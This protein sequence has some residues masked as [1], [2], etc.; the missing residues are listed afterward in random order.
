MAAPSTGMTGL[1]TSW[2][3]TANTALLAACDEP[4]FTLNI[5]G[6]VQ[7]RTAFAAGLTTTRAGATI[8]GWSGTI[9]G[10]ARLGTSPPSGYLGLVTFAGGYATHVNS[11]DM[12]ITCK[13]LEI[14]SW[15]LAATAAGWRSFMPGILG[16]GGS[17]SALIDVTTALANPFAPNTASSAA[18]FKIGEASAVAQTLA[19]NIYPSALSIAAAVAD[20]NTVQYSYVGDSTLTAAGA[21]NLFAA[22]AVGTPDWDTSGSDGVPDADLI[23]QASSGRTYT[24][25]AFWTSIGIRVQ[26]AGWTEISIGFQGAGALAIG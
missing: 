23:L 21:S 9:T 22:G 1:V 26:P 25:P 16:W 11:W 18:T 14:T 12:Q 6:G 8:R 13:P 5:D 15:T 10:R 2:V 3:G 20:L 7:D 24:G 19:G 17:Y 4:S